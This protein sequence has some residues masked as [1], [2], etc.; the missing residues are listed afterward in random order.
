MITEG[1]MKE[2][3]HFGFDSSNGLVLSSA[4]SVNSPAHGV[5]DGRTQCRHLIVVDN[6]RS[7]C[8]SDPHSVQ[9]VDGAFAI[10]MLGHVAQT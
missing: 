1:T 3:P 7:A 9:V 8:G 5:D 2:E 4:L 6:L 10:L